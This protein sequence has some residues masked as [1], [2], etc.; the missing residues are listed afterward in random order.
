MKR[1]GK[2]SAAEERDMH[3]L[4]LDC[5]GGSDVSPTHRSIIHGNG[6]V[7]SSEIVFVCKGSVSDGGISYLKDFVSARSHLQM[8]G[9]AV[10][11]QQKLLV[12]VNRPISNEVQ[13]PHQWLAA[14]S[15]RHRV[16]LVPPSGT[17]DFGNH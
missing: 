2:P 15:P 3:I 12:A 8:R 6:S 16:L 4:L 14:A 1:L 7:V 11:C 17:P 10:A 9:G 5:G 13:L